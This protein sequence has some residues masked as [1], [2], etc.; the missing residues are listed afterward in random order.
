MSGRRRQERFG[1]GSVP[2]GPKEWLEEAPVCSLLAFV[3][4]CLYLVQLSEGRRWGFTQW[5]GG[6][7]EFYRRGEVWRLLVDHVHHGDLF[8]LLFNLL[9]LLRL[10]DPLERMAGTGR[11]LLFVVGA[12]LFIGL[13]CNL[14]IEPNAIGLSGIVYAIFGLLWVLRRHVMVFRQA[15]DEGTIKILLVWLFLCIPLS[16][17]TSFQV[18]N[19]GHFSGLLFGMAVGWGCRLWRH[20]NLP[21]RIALFLPT[22]LLPAGLYLLVHPAWGPG[23]HFERAARASDPAVKIREYTEGL[24]L[25]P[26]DHQARLELARVLLA[27]KQPKE[28]RLALES[29]LRYDRD[30]VALIDLYLQVLDQL[31]D[32]EEM[33][34]WIEHLGELDPDKASSWEA[35]LRQKTPPGQSKPGE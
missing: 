16:L 27:Q 29:L 30:D 32:R 21:A 7:L 9:W 10:G 26:G 18:A 23:L 19:V 34:A 1:G 15:L 8:H 2:A 31:D 24:A 33:G 20:L 13:A 12:G 5:G 22:L 28:T 4:I 6:S 14:T 3:S 35:R 11:M 25:D 17:F